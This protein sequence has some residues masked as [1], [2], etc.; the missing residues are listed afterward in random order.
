MYMTT[1]PD[2]ELLVSM[3]VAPAPEL[4]FFITWLRLLF[5]FTHSYFLLSGRASSGMKNEIYQVHETKRIYQQVG[6]LIFF[7]TT[8]ALTMRKSAKK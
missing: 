4:Y 6:R 1:A 8:S 3:S 2:P 5:V 7:F